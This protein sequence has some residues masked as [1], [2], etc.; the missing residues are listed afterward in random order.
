[1]GI[2][3]SNTEEPLDFGDPSCRMIKNGR[4]RECKVELHSSAAAIE[5]SVF[6]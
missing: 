4:C 2:A 3:Y 1:M 5:Y 6:C